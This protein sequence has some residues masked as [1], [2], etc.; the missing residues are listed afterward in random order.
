M[1]A[2]AEPVLALFEKKHQ[3]EVPL[4]QRQYVWTEEQ[5]W[6]PLWEDIS[7]KF[8][9]FIEGHTDGPVH[10]LGAMVLDQKYTRTTAV[11]KRQIIDGQQRL[12]TLQVF[13]AAFRDYCRTH[14]CDEL[15][16]EC[17][18]YT[19]N[20]G[21]MNDPEV[22]RFKVWPTKSDQPSFAAVMT[23][24]SR[25]EVSAAFPLRY[26]KWA[27]KPEPRP[28]IVDAYLFFYEQIETFFENPS[29]ELMPVEPLASRLEKSF[30][31]L[32]AALQ[33]V[34]IDLDRDDDAQVIFETLNARGA[35]LL[36][37]DLL[38]NFIFLRAAR[39][40]E[41]QEELYSEYWEPF[42]DSFWRFEI[43]QG[44]LRR[45]RS[46]L[47][48]QHFLAS[49]QMV[50]VPIKHLFVEYKYWI[51]RTRPFPTVRAELEKI[52]KNR[53]YFR[54]LL[55]PTGESAVARLAGMLDTFDMSTLYPL[56]LHL[57]DAELSQE[58][59]Y[60]VDRIFQSYII[61]RAV[62]GLT[63]KNYNRLFLSVIRRMRTEGTSA[64]VLSVILSSLHGESQ[65][66]PSDERFAEAWRSRIY[67]LLG[68]NRIEYILRRINE[69]FIT[70]MHESI[71][72]DGPLTVE[73]IMPQSWIAHWPLPD[74]RSGVPS[75][76]EAEEP[77]NGLYDA[78]RNR[79]YALNTFGNLTI[80][81][82]SLNSSVSN[83][84]W[85]EKKHAILSTS[86]LPMNQSLFQFDDWN[87]AAIDLR[88]RDLLR[89]AIMLWPGPS[90]EAKDIV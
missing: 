1:Q 57:L 58:Q 35:P 60:D 61:R 47:F 74:G 52:A 80:L 70:S 26:R 37:A 32:R 71:R 4:F 30:A 25:D 3:I 31:A 34:V 50:D 87:E 43:T 75:W 14:G 11:D 21:M 51:E 54:V 44:R 24:G 41:N 56:L 16:E 12:T 55:Q 18:P 83:G 48:M 36:P 7:R 53:E 19:L 72:V 40:G 13:L 27:R 86:L 9:A 76:P 45:P 77:D 49:Q 66:W 15:G 38:R 63:A 64:H 85:S 33:V 17:E 82:R 5:Q 20:K 67:G 22:D 65:E 73:H 79:D 62:C 78:S 42:D 90:R 84:A 10:F 23:A 8:S 39:L 46:D 89:R 68:V 28:R 88:N 2:S 69:T 6:A 29:D 81:T 59:W